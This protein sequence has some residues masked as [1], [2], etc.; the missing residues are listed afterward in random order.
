MYLSIVLW[1]CCVF[2]LM[3]E[4]LAFVLIYHVETS[5]LIC[6]TDYLSGFYSL[7]VTERSFRTTCGYFI[8]ILTSLLCL[9][10]IGSLLSV[11]F[12]T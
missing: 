7:H 4:D 11:F 10:L 1:I 6:S 12:Y 2:C 3:V 9:Y 5:Q 8:V